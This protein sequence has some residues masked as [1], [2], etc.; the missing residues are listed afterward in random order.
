M[1]SGADEG[2]KKALVFHAS[3]DEKIDADFS[4]ADPRAL[5]KTPA[6]LVPLPPHPEEAVIERAGGRFGGALHFPKKGTTRPSYTGQGMLGYHEKNWNATV[7][8]NSSPSV[9]RGT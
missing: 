5:A 4:T 1:P 8:S 7:S 6:G 2:L 3:F 9:A